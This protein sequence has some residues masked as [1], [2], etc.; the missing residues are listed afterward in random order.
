MDTR[1]LPQV[2]V[3][4]SPGQGRHLVAVEKI[5]VGEVRMDLIVRCNSL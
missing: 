2:R 3:E 1:Y 5:A 4:H